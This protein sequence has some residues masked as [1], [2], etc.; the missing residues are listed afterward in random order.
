MTILANAQTVGTFLTVAWALKSLVAYHTWT[1]DEVMDDV[2]SSPLPLNEH[3]LEYWRNLVTPYYNIGPVKKQFKIRTHTMITSFIAIGLCVQFIKSIRE[4]RLDI[5]RIVGRLTLGVTLLAYPH[6]TML[7][8]GFFHQTAKYIEA[9]VL[10]MIPYYAIRGWIQIRNK[11]IM[12]H[13]SSMIMFASCFY[14]FGLSRLVMMAMNAIH[15]GPWAKYTGLGDWR[16]WSPEDV[17][18][19]FG[20][21]VAIGFPLNFGFALTLSS[22][23]ISQSGT[24]RQ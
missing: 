19:F 2:A 24:C 21:S 15:S 4:K 3:G 22:D 5:H 7:M 14:Y 9:P 16:N 23:G 20:I 17:H 18:D 10:F 6:F 1:L 8:A 11:D 13:R 12:G